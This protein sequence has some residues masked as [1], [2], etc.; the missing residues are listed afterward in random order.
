MQVGLK[1]AVDAGRGAP[2]YPWLTFR[3]T[4][5]PHLP[6]TQRAVPP[7]PPYPALPTLLL[8]PSPLQVHRAPVVAMRYNA[9]FDTVISTDNKGEPGA[10]LSVLP[11]A[12][13]TLSRLGWLR[14]CGVVRVVSAGSPSV[15]ARA[16]QCAC[17]PCPCN[18]APGHTRELTYLRLHAPPQGL[19]EYWCGT[20]YGHPGD[21]RVG[22]S[23]KLDTDLFDLAKAKTTA[24]SLEVRCRGVRR[25]A[26][27]TV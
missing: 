5:A 27:G 7:F 12:V 4:L 20:S 14:L 15:L 11:S 13:S 16:S 8:L 22:W 21:G 26:R 2:P 3:P 25:G 17:R 6:S 1:G 23:S 24:R 9:P 18:P 19:I 10:L